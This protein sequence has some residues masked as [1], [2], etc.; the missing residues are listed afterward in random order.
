MEAKAEEASPAEGEKEA[1]TSRGAPASNHSHSKQ[2]QLTVRRL[3]PNFTLDP[4]Q[5]V[6]LEGSVD[7]LMQ[8]LNKLLAWLPLKRILFPPEWVTWASPGAL[9]ITRVHNAS[10]GPLPYQVASPCVD[11]RYFAEGMAPPLLHTHTIP[12]VA[13]AHTIGSYH[14]LNVGHPQEKQEFDYVASFFYKEL[15]QKRNPATDP[16]STNHS[17]LFSTDQFRIHS[18]YRIENVWTYA[19]H[20]ACAV[21]VAMELSHPHQRAEVKQLVRE[22]RVGAIFE[23]A[24][25]RFVF[26]G[27][28][29]TDPTKLLDAG[30][31]LRFCNPKSKYGKA[32]YFA[33][34]PAYPHRGRY[35]YS[36]RP[37]PSA[38]VH[39]QVFLASVVCG[40]SEH[41]A[42][43]AK[44]VKDP[45]KDLQKLGAHTLTA[46]PYVTCSVGRGF[47]T[48][49]MVVAFADQHVNVAYLI[50]YVKN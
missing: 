22:G 37:A 17:V 24:R 4:G 9:G 19:R 42:K 29:K 23:R 20:Y 11:A 46:G 18:V 7:E 5:E 28:G 13:P 34:S 1:E 33:T 48:T 27:C 32:H 47:G 3:R 25:T 39:Y 43:I 26:H 31:A 10:P 8:Q 44:R 14:R 35:V 6:I 40:C 12:G 15:A 38:P 21:K 30:C 41:M 45:V 36:Y 50:D 16:S 2:Q 49:E